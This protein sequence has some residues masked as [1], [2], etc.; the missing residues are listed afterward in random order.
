MNDSIGNMKMRRSIRQYK[1]DR[2]SPDG[3]AQIIGDR[4][5]AANG[6]GKQS[7]AIVVFSIVNLRGDTREVNAPAC[8]V[9]R[10]KLALN[11]AAS[12]ALPM[13]ASEWPIKS[14]C[15]G[16]IHPGRHCKSAE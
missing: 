5:F 11:T 2:V 12:F 16:G 8:A 6:M 3:I 13:T 10:R 7:L 14:P 1:P 4:L 9:S 15:F